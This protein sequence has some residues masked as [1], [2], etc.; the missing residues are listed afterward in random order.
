MIGISSGYSKG[1]VFAFTKD[2]CNYLLKD[3]FEAWDFS[4]AE[5]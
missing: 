3:S 4:W 1:V 2:K 5:V